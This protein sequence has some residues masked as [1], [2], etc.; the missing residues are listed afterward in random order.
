MRTKTDMGCTILV[1]QDLDQE[2]LEGFYAEL[3]ASLDESPKRI[4]LDCSLLDHATSGH[5]NILW[6][7]QTR[8]EQAGISMRLLSV[9]YGLE[10]VLRILDLYDLFV[11]ESAG[12]GARP[13]TDPDPTS[14]GQPPALECRF[15]ATME[16][17]TGTLAKLHS[18]LLHLGLPATYA[19]DLE[20]VF[21]EVATN[22]RRHGG[23]KEDDTVAFKVIMGK[24]EITLRFADAGL[25][26]DP[27]G[28]RSAFDPD[29]AIRLKQ[30]N[31]IGLTMVKRLVDTISYE[32]VGNRENVLILGK[33]LRPGW[34]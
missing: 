17:I 16:G 8:C 22:I 23:L 1:P 34:R 19:F 11:V 14:S 13:E 10:R 20:T 27:T 7:A 3:K 4:T 21:Y 30:S 33:R 9:A 5:I 29:L 25:P 26:F 28:K 18:F 12:G 24:N 6:E 31:G 32:R 2:T 15:K